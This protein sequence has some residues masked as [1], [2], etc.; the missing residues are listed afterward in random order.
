MQTLPQDW[1]IVKSV[2]IDE[3]GSDWPS[4]KLYSE[5]LENA[6]RNRDT[7]DEHSCN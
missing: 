5:P 7:K 1:M 4:S 2:F 6:N 3:N